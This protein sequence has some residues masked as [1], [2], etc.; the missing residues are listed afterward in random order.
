MSG[1][2]QLVSMTGLTILIIIYA[3]GGVELRG[4]LMRIMA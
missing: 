2:C 4:Y 3:I 1:V